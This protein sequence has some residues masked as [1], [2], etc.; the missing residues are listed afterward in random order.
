MLPGYKTQ[1]SAVLGVLYERD[2]RTVKI[3]LQSLSES[4]P[5]LLI[6]HTVPTPLRPICMDLISAVNISLNMMRAI[7]SITHQQEKQTS[8]CVERTS[9]CFDPSGSASVSGS[10]TEEKTDEKRKRERDLNV[11]H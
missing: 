11:K 8:R 3:G 10:I 9:V 7:S 6:T 4:H 2:S 5:A 1:A